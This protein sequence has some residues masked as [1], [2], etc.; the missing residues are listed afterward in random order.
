MTSRLVKALALG[1]L[2][3][4]VTTG[5]T[6][7]EPLPLPLPGAPGYPARAA[8]PGAPEGDEPEVLAKGPVHEAF[9]STAEGPA[10]SPVVEQRPP[11]PIEELPPDQKPAGDNV[12]WI[13]GY[14]HW[15]DDNDRYLWVSGFWRQVPPGR[16]WVPG[17]W[18]EVRGGW[19]YVS[20]FFQEVAPNP[21]PN[22]PAVQPEIE[23]LPPPP[24]SVEGGPVVPAP[25]AT[26]FYVPGSWVWRGR[27]VWRPGVWVDYRPDWVWV[28]ARYVWTPAGYV[29][30][31]GYWD[32]PLAARGV[33]FAP[34]AFPRP[35]L[36]RPRFVYTP[37]YVV[38]EP[39]LFGALF[40]RRG[41]GNYFFG[42]YFDPRFG[43]RGYSAWCGTFGG[44][45]F[46]IGF[47]A[48]RTWG[49][50]PLWSYYS[51]SFRTAPAWRTG[52]A[53]V[54]GGRFAGTVARPPVNLV[55]QNTVINNITKVNVTNVTNNITVV[56]GAPTVNNTNVANVAMVAPLKVAPDLT[57]TKFQPVNAEA[58]KA[59]AATAQQL[60][61][62]AAQRNRL[63]TFVAKQAAPAGVPAAGQPPA[64]PQ[65]IKLDVPKTVVARAQVTDEKKA[66][67][68]NPTRASKVDPKV[69][70]KLSVNP[71]VD[72][73]LPIGPKVDPKLP[74][75]PK[76]DPKL[77]TNPKI[78]PTP[79]VDPKLP[80]NPKVDP[81]LPGSPKIDPTPKVD[82]KLPVNPKVDPKLPVTPPKIDPKLPVNPLPKID[83]KLPSPPPAGQP[84][85]DP[86]PPV[87]QPKLGTKPPVAPPKFEPQLPVPQPK[88]DTKPPAPPV[89]LPKLDPKPPV[90]QPKL[91]PKPPAPQPPVIGSKP[92]APAVQPKIDPRP[93]ARPTVQPKVNNPPPAPPKVNLPPARPAV[94]PKVNLP[95]ARPAVPPRGGGGAPARGKGKG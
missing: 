77:P 43:R 2:L 66:P 4:A 7:Q 10:A 39:C 16:V 3:V 13:P 91:D 27:Y 21:V 74:A 89:T 40:V 67:P 58:R 87:V 53:D 93:P 68:P 22:Q 17:S 69:E 28:P 32:Y 75:N 73:K 72:P 61:E 88:F 46:S 86:K 8:Q 83:P 82:P 64:R 95:P 38:S 6:A 52:L 23:Y 62:V 18:R 5:L 84:K 63:E 94:Q 48:G 44:G 78:D 1:A 60:R 79:K 30:C 59:E 50:D 45:G 49:Y 70:P 92:P 37:T 56:N 26:S 54:Y 51:L 31:D 25:N 11:D 9:A 42:D 80:I 55:Q 90:V 76:I 15:D 24:A 41:C 12:Q 14:W 47:G 65:S 19:Q 29:F 20:G 81:K 34:V 71:K 35:L 57:R 85:I 33:L 36:L